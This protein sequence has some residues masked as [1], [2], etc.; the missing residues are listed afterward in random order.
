MH[1]LKIMGTMRIGYLIVGMLVMATGVCGQRDSLQRMDLGGC[2]EY[3]L[4]NNIQIKKSKVVFE[5][6]GIT[7]KQAK[8]QRLPNLSASASENFV[9]RP[10]S[11]V[12][13]FTRVNDNTSSGNFSVNSSVVLYNGG[14][15]SN[16]IKQ[17]ALMV[18]ANK[19]AV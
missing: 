4:A 9:N 18:E 14:K 2:V 7:S 5:Q 3:A 16:Y 13:G 15:I 11:T 12:G 1:R 8:A 6:S 17:Q 19:Y 10:L